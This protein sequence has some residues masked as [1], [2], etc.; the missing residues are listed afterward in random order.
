MPTMGLL[1]L[2]DQTIATTWGFDQLLPE[3][4][5]IVKEARLYPIE[6][7]PKEVWGGSNNESNDDLPI[8]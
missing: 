8:I 7:S 4:L 3:N 6:D 1:G 5:C 2:A